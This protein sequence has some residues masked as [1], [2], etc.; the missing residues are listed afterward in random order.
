MENLKLE[1][2]FLI[3]QNVITQLEFVCV[4][5]TGAFCYCGGKGFQIFH[6]RTKQKI[7]SQPYSPPLYLREQNSVS[8]AYPFLCRDIILE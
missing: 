5:R 7:P 8:L 1:K 6:E 3:R 2:E 4:T